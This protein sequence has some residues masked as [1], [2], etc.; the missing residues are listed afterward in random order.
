MIIASNGSFD[1][2]A[3]TCLIAVKKDGGLIKPDNQTHF[4][5]SGYVIRKVPLAPVGDE[6]EIAEDGQCVAAE[7]VTARL[8]GFDE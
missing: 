4:G 6:E 5:I 3:E 1:F 7:S 8:A 2:C